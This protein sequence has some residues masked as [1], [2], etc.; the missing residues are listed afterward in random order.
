MKV[1]EKK[2]CS[3]YRAHKANRDIRTD[4]RTDAR[5]HSPNHTRTA[6]YN[7]YIPSNAFSRGS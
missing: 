4:G 5:T 6:L 1:I 2:N 7:Y 3:L